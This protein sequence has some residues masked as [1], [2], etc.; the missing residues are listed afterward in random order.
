MTFSDPK[1]F[2]ISL[3]DARVVLL[4]VCH[5]ETCHDT[6]GKDEESQSVTDPEDLKYDVDQED[7]ANSIAAV[8]KQL[9]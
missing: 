8:V 6:N 1:S 3:K 5:V 2:K 9:P 7:C 4:P